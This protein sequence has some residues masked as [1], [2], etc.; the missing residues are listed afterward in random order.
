METEAEGDVG[1]LALLEAGALDACDL[2]REGHFVGVDRGV[3]FADCGHGGAE[4]VDDFVAGGFDAVDAFEFENAVALGAVG[5]DVGVFED[6]F[7]VGSR[8]FD[9][10]DVVAGDGAVVRN[11]RFGDCDDIGGADSL[12][13]ADDHVFDAGY[14][15]HDEHFACDALGGF[16]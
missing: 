15:F 8:C 16:Y 7:E 9:A 11:F 2:A 10:V 4:F 1:H 14:E 6:G 3:D 5:V 13:A 12:D